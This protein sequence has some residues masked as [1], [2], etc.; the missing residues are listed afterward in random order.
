MKTVERRKA[1]ALRAGQGLSVREIAA[2]L[3]VSRST[4]S[5]WLRDVPLTTVQEDRLRERNPAVSGQLAGA[6]RNAELARDRRR[7][8]QEHGRVLARRSDALHL[9]G[10]MLYW[11]E[12]EKASRNA[13]RISNTDP[14][15]L[16]LFLDFLRAT[17]AIPEERVRVTCHLFSDHVGHQAAIERDWLRELGLPEASLTRSIV[18][19]QSRRSTGKRA[20]MLPRGTCRLAVNS[21][22]VVQSIFG[23]IQEYGR[24]ERPEWLG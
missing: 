15:L 18:N 11:A 12:G 24:I 20:R 8:Y 13:A 14:A 23:S 4:A 1:I 2:A 6:R 19:R 21:T 22:F 3:D 7:P 10:V 17:F 5:R 9:A 16:R